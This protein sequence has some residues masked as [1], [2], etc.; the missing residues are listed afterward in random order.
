MLFRSGFCV[1]DKK[2]ILFLSEFM[3]IVSFFGCAVFFCECFMFLYFAPRELLQGLH[4][5]TRL[6]MSLRPGVFCGH[7]SSSIK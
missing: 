4:A 5:A 7:L 1:S 3:F 6:S 2:G